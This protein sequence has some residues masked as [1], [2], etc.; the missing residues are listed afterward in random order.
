[1]TITIIAMMIMMMVIGGFEMGEAHLGMRCRGCERCSGGDGE[2]ALE[3]ANGAICSCFL[4]GS[5][6]LVSLAYSLYHT[7]IHS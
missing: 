7:Q 3:L 2:R 4:G 6:V 5:L 1:M